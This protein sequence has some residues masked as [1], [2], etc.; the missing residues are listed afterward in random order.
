MPA[1][2][3]KAD[4]VGEARFGKFVP[5]QHDKCVLCQAMETTRADPT[6]DHEEM[7]RRL[8]RLEH[9]DPKRLLSPPTG[10]SVAPGARDEST[11]DDLVST[12]AW[13]HESASPAQK[14]TAVSNE[15]LFRNMSPRVD[16]TESTLDVKE[17]RYKSSRTITKLLAKSADDT[18]IMNNLLNNKALMQHSKAVLQRVS[19]YRAN[20]DA[21][22]SALVAADWNK[23]LSIADIQQASKAK[24]DALELERDLTM[25]ETRQEAHG[26]CIE[27]A[28]KGHSVLKFNDLRCEIRRMKKVTGYFHHQRTGHRDYDRHGGS[29]TD[30][31]EDDEVD[32]EGEEVEAEQKVETS[33]ARE[34]TFERTERM[35]RQY[36]QHQS[37]PGTPTRAGEGMTVSNGSPAPITLTESPEPQ[38]EGPSM[39]ITAMQEFSRHTREQEDN[40]SVSTDDD[41]FRYERALETISTTQEAAGPSTEVTAAFPSKGKEKKDSKV[42]GLLKR[43]A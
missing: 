16:I 7:M 19:V 1:E 37:L 3:K 10:G 42:E 9:R 17:G 39:Y 28:K 2:S 21:A 12:S 32:E 20:R 30:D 11:F 43:M 18:D 24:A 8:R 29:Y 26:A 27:F 23:R 14:D 25:L 5:A 36:Q 38:T 40:A 4:V 6:L 34:G 33:F 41:P 13:G 22:Q 31:D 35:R 15:G